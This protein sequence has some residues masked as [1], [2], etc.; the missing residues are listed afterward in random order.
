MIFFFQF[1]FFFSIQHNGKSHGHRYF[2]TS[3]MAYDTE[4][5]NAVEKHKQ[6]ISSAGNSSFPFSCSNVTGDHWSTLETN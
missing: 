2:L 1:E 5:T 3:F 6:V 4:S